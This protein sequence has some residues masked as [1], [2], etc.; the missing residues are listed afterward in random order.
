MLYENPDFSRMQGGMGDS[1]YEASHSDMVPYPALI[2]DSEEDGRYNQNQ[3]F[4]QLV[5][6]TKR[7]LAGR[8]QC[9]VEDFLLIAYGSKEKSGFAVVYAAPNGIDVA[10][11]S[12]NYDE[13]RSYAAI[14]ADST[15]VVY[16]HGKEYDTRSMTFKI[17]AAFI[18]RIKV[19]G[20]D[21]PDSYENM[22]DNIAWYTWTYV[23]DKGT[24]R[25]AARV[26]RDGSM[27]KTDDFGDRAAFGDRALRFRPTILL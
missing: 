2:I 21:L 23:F 22:L 12:Y 4:E 19:E 20:S 27:Y 24:T 1:I 9:S 13:N 10:N 11:S 7:A 17:Y 5:A 26:F 15:H 3:H 8:Y 25:A 14:M 6:D 18:E 16:V